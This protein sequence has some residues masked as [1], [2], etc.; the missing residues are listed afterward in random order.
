MNVS[1]Q[2]VLTVLRS[3]AAVLER[4]ATPP[5]RGT[6]TRVWNGLA[7]VEI[8]PDA[9]RDWKFDHYAALWW[10]AIRTIVELLERQDGDLTPAQVAYLRSTFVG[11]AGS[12][13]DFSIQPADDTAPHAERDNVELRR[14]SGRLRAELDRLARNAGPEDIR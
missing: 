1:V 7:Y 12:F 8:A 5:P 10:V 6:H 14:L 2:T 3:I 9:L 11:T 13:Q 4:W